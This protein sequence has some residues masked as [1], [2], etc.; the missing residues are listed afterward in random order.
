MYL[1]TPICRV[2]VGDR[3]TFQT[4][5]GLLIDAQVSLSEQDRS[6][7]CKVT[8]FDPGLK[9]ANVLFT[10]FQKVG[11]IIIPKGLLVEPQQT[12]NAVDDTAIN[13]G[14]VNL[15]NIPKQPKGDEL[16]R[17]I[18]ASCSQYGVTDINQ[19]AYILATAQHESKMGVYYVEIASG[20]AYEGRRDL[21]NTSPGDGVKYKGRGLVQITG[22]RN[23]ADWG[24]RLKID[25]VG[26]PQLAELAQYAIPILI[27]GMRDGTFTGRKL[28]SYINASRTDFINARRIVNGLDR[29]TL[30]AG[31]A[32]QWV[33]KIP[34]YQT[35]N[36][37]T[38]PPQ[39]ASQVSSDLQ[40]NDTQTP[41][42]NVNNGIQ[43]KFELGFNDSTNSTSFNYLLTDVVATNNI[44][45]TLTMSGRQVRYVIGKGKKF[46]KIHQN[47]TVRQFAKTVSEKIGANLVIGEGVTDNE[48]LF[49]GVHQ[50]ENDYKFL[51]KLAERNG[52]FI[53]SDEKTI[54]IE[55]LKKNDKTFEIKVQSLLPGSEWA[56]SASE[57]RILSFSNDPKTNDLAQVIG[58]VSQLETT[59]KQG[60]LDLNNVPDGEKIGKGFESRLN[61]DTLAQPEL[62][63]LEPGAIIK[64]ENNRKLG[65]ALT[66]EYRTNEIIHSYSSNGL[67]TILNIYLPVAMKIR[68]TGQVNNSPIGEPPSN[69]PIPDNLKSTPKRGD[70][71]AGFRVTSPYGKRPQPYPGASSFHKGSD[72]NT[73]VGTNLYPPIKPGQE[74]TVNCRYQEGIGAG[75]YIEGVVGDETVVC[76]HCS[77]CLGQRGGGI[78]GTVKAGEVMGKTGATGTKAPHLHLGIKDRNRKYFPPS[79]GLIYWVLTGKQPT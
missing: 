72:L 33:T 6:S 78:S 37:P 43:I 8:V 20:R 16:V 65:T 67:E 56:D 54:K 18:I 49:N 74:I 79:A 57:D 45:N 30:I 38:P 77:E 68:E 53:R 28:S 17:L 60:I 40:K 14:K 4:G 41:E 34:S 69:I 2:T 58:E 66:R 9:I 46:Y 42:I 52:L 25:L 22:K 32:R 24:N 35:G 75:L 11:G 47:I 62:L 13:S 61:L 59:I 10:E 27:V 7:N 29:A 5:D 36:V 73:P 19:V 64:I 1:K 70:M 55:K 71:I 26:N 51:L 31:Y 21:G 48:R 50:K 23:Y 12:T 63:A 15:S 3:F 76:M 39:K 44:P